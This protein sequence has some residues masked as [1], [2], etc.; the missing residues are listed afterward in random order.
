M[1]DAG[2]VGEQQT[3]R[4]LGRTAAVLPRRSRGRRRLQDFGLAQAL[5]VDVGAEPGRG[6]GAVGA[7]QVGEWHRVRAV[8]R[9]D[10]S[11]EVDDALIGQ[12]S[13]HDA[14]RGHGGVCPAEQGRGGIDA[15][16]VWLCD[17]MRT[18]ISEAARGSGPGRHPTRTAQAQRDV[19]DRTVDG[20]ERGRG[21]ARR[22]RR[23]IAAIGA[24]RSEGAL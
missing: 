13:R 5:G 21:R 9:G 3:K 8:D 1:L 7:D 18:P 23:T 19:G 15:R 12:E 16:P 6:R 17:P 14:D 20:V 11:V 4:H 24:I 22:R 2:A 10:V